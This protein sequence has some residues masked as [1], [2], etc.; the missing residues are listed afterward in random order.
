MLGNNKGSEEDSEPVH[1]RFF[2]SHDEQYLQR[3]FWEQEIKRATTSA[4]DAP[5]DCIGTFAS[6]DPIF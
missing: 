5:F 2:D 4:K 1:V 6:Y 3:A